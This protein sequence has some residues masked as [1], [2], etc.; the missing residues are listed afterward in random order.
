MQVFAGC[1]RMRGGYTVAGDRVTFG[2]MAG[3]LMAC[4]PPLGDVESAVARALT[5]TQRFA[6]AEKALSAQPYLTGAQFTIADAYLFTVLNWAPM[7]KVDLAPFP[8]L[9]AFQAR[10]A[11]RPA[12]QRALREE[13]LLKDAAAA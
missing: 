10:V 11:A 2:P 3:T 1:N 4:P 9:V 5:G 6:I 8:A 12:V 7:L 13:G